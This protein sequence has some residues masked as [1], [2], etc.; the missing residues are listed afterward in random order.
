MKKSIFILMTLLLFLAPAVFGAVTDNVKNW[1]VMANE[2]PDFD[3]Y[4]DFSGNTPDLI[5]GGD[6]TFINNS[7]GFLMDATS[8]NLTGGKFYNTTFSISAW[9]KH[10]GTATQEMIVTNN[11]GAFNG[12][13]LML[14]DDDKVRFYLNGVDCKDDVALN[15]NKWHHLFIQAEIQTTGKIA[16]YIDGVLNQSCSG[17]TG[18]GNYGRIT[19]GNDPSIP[20]DMD[21][22]IKNVA[23]WSVFDNATANASFLYSQGRT[24]NPYSSPPA[25]SNF[26]ITASNNYGETITSFNATIGT[27]VFYSNA[28][29]T[30]NTNI[31][32]DNT[33]LFNITVEAP[34]HDLR[35]YYNYNVSSDLSAELNFSQYRLNVTAIDQDN[36]SILEFTLSVNGT[37]YTTTDG[38]ITLNLTKNAIYELLID[39]FGYAYDSANITMTD[40]WTNKTFNLILTNSVFIYIR[41]EITDATITDNVT[42]RWSTNTT[43]WENVT[44]TGELFIHNLTPDVYELLFYSSNYS[45]RSYTLT[46]GNRST[47]TLNAYMLSSEYTTIFTVK[48]IDTGSTM[49]DVSMTMYKLI[50]ST[51]TTVESKY[52]DISGKAQFSYDP[53]ASYKFYLSKSDYDDYVF[54]LNPILF[55]EYDVLMSRTSVLNYSVDFDNIGIIY[56]P[57]QFVNEQNVTFNF[58]ISSPDGLLT[59]YGIK[60]TYPGGS[61]SSTGNNAIGEQLTADVNL[62]GATNF[63]HVVLEYNYSTSLAGVRTYV[64]NLPITTNQTAGT[65]MA[66][67]DKTYGMGIFERMLIATLCII[68]VVGISVMIGQVVPGLALGMFIYG[69]MVYIGFIPLW[70][71]LPSMLIGVLFLIWKSGGY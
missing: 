59:N 7:D 58:L 4:R 12:W 13:K 48:D 16:V 21:G 57:T 64:V 10:T 30:I 31:S 52:T 51:W 60:L 42:I 32:A 55:S 49:E 62:T 71:I 27:D 9:I 61:D 11:P 18:N 41:D 63:D 39:A 6:P 25:G 20:Q 44:N 43:T 24:Y 8:E 50:N 1:Y 37:N 45:T 38:E 69:F 34:D 23:F 5:K 36:A 65:W 67:K 66:N 14:D 40:W 28:T 56:S 29:G 54:Y 46:V 47:Q 22:Y 3:P 68:F 15:I 2:T 35:I 19:I 53:I 17:K 33:S 26:S 70:V